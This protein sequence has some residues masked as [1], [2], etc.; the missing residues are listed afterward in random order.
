[1]HTRYSTAIFYFDATHTHLTDYS[2]LNFELWQ[3]FQLEDL[4][5]TGFIR[6]TGFKSLMSASD[7]VYAVTALLDCSSL[8]MPNR[9]ING[10]QQENESEQLLHAFNVAYDALNPK[11][12]M[13]MSPN[14]LGGGGGGEGYDLANLVNG[15]DLSGATGLGAG[16]RLAMSLQ[17]SIV[18]TSM[19][20]VEKHAIVRLSHFRY[21]YVHA[22]SKGVNRGDQGA[23]SSATMSTTLI[24]TGEGTTEEDMP[25]IFARPLALRKLA[26]F[27]MDMHRENGKWS[28]SGGRARPLILMAEKP[29]TNTYV[30]VGYNYYE[31]TGDVAKNRFG[32]N[33]ELATKTL[34][35]RVFFDATSWDGNMC[36]VEASIVQR[37]IEQLHY[38]MDAR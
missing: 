7:M 26:M 2:F 4:T 19:S 5:Y 18:A 12:S 10:T 9:K 16:V 27:L 20:L 3:E 38:L 36:E 35:G 15:G 14:Q 23:A 6:V 29:Q 22:T 11:S 24:P 37:F 33:F 8:S 34:K 30:V 32:K 13:N 21:A 31:E 25:H 17:R 28:S 1:V